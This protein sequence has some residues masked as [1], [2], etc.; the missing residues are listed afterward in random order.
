MQDI[1]HYEKRQESLAM[2]EILA[3]GKKEAEE[4]KAQPNEPGKG[5]M[6]TTARRIE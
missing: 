3:L 6:S 5:P 1:R 4:G 2:L